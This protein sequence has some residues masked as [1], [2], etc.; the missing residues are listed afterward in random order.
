MLTV[1]GSCDIQME[2]SDRQMGLWVKCS[3]EIPELQ[4]DFLKAT[5][6]S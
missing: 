2:T 3:G 6:E 5:V 4:I 1:G